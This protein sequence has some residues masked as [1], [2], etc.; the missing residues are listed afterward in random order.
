MRQQGIDARESDANGDD[1]AVTLTNT[2]AI[3][4]AVA[5]SDPVTGAN[6]FGRHVER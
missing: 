4:V 2:V 1:I 5:N 6:D 3:S